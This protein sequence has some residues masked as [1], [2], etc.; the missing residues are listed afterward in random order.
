MYNWLILLDETSSVKPVCCNG[1]SHISQICSRL[2]FIFLTLLKAEFFCCLTEFWRVCAILY[3]VMYLTY[4]FIFLWI[5]CEQTLSHFLLLLTCWCH[6]W[7][8]QA[9]QWR[10]NAQRSQEPYRCNLCS[11]EI[12]CLSFYSSL[13]TIEVWNVMWF[14]TSLGC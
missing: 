11:A 13:S 12:K 10:W 14:S 8:I 5:K 9:E 3:K 2:P 4:Y 6:S 1:P 7:G